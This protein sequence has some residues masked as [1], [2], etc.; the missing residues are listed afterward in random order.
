VFDNLLAVRSIWHRQELIFY[1]VFQA[2][3]S[4]NAIAICQVDMVLFIKDL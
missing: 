4:D 3:Y 2:L 1:D